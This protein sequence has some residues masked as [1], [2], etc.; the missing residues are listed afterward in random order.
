MLQLDALGLPTPAQLVA[1][2]KSV[3]AGAFATYCWRRA[4]DD[5]VLPVY[6]TPDHL[7]ACRAAGIRLVAIVVPGSN[8]TAADIGASLDAAQHFGWSPTRDLIAVDL[9]TFS[10]PPGGWEIQWIGAAR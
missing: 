10:L 9:E 5:S 1:D 6:V 4:A 2:C 3:G 7:A 8:P